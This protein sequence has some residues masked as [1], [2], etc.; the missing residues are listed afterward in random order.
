MSIVL[1]VYVCFLSTIA[2]LLPLFLIQLK[3]ECPEV[4]LN[5]IS[6]LDCVNEVSTCH[7]LPTVVLSV[8]KTLKIN[9]TSCYFSPQN[10]LF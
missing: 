3:D 6:N 9:V 2:H 8:L 10:I 1:S 5:I 4:R 7:S